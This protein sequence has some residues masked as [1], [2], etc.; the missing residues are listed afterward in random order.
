MSGYARTSRGENLVF[1]IFANNNTER[2]TDATETLDAIG[3][4]MVQT[5]GRPS[6]EHRR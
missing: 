1:S 2:G 6:K 5:L 4:A 3:M